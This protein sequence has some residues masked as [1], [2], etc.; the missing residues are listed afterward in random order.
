MDYEKIRINFKPNG[1]I[2]ILFVGECRPPKNTFFY[3]KDSLL[4]KQTKMAFEEYYGKSLSDDEFL[5]C[6]KKYCWLYDLYS[7]PVSE[8][9]NYSER[10]RRVKSGITDLKKTIDKENPDIIIVVGKAKNSGMNK[11]VEEVKR[12]YINKQNISLDFPLNY[13]SAGY[14]QKIVNVLNEIKYKEL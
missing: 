14:R 7:E 1:V 13:L 11:V 10:K 3:N 5:S 2:K 6:F 4:F 12:T 9:K 8:S